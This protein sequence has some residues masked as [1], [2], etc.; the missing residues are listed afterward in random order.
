MRDFRHQIAER[1]QERQMIA[2]N[3]TTYLRRRVK[4]ELKRELKEITPTKRKGLT[5]TVRRNLSLFINLDEE[6]RL[7]PHPSIL[8]PQ[9][10]VRKTKNH[11]ETSLKVRFL[12]HATVPF[13]LCCYVSLFV[14]AGRT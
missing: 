9:R 4:E 1:N 13:S 2:I 12:P 6:G 8:L 10:R 11:Q 14:G 3:I 5:R 7:H